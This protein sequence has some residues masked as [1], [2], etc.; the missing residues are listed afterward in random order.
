MTRIG[1][2]CLD[3]SDLLKSI[4][5]QGLRR[6]RGAERKLRYFRN[7]CNVLMIVGL[8][9]PTSFEI[10]RLCVLGPW[11][12]TSSL[13]GQQASWS[14]PTPINVNWIKLQQANRAQLILMIAFI[15]SNCSLVPCCWV[16]L[17]KSSCI[18]CLN[19]VSIATTDRAA[20]RAVWFC[21]V[22]QTNVLWAGPTWIH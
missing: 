14:C 12:E 22:R 2:S 7:V 21:P 15:T 9:Q 3:Y 13:Q 5:I 10:Q 4:W 6:S 17:L 18:W 16:Y 11:Q 8:L 20:G 1:V 19:I